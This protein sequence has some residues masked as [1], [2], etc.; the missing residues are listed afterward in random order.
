MAIGALVLLP[1]A[2]IDSGQLVPPF[3]SWS[4]WGWLALL[5]AVPGTG[6]YLMNWAHLHVSLTLTGLLTLAIP[7]L[8]AAGGWL[9]LDQRLAPVQVLGM[10]VVLST[11]VVAVRRDARLHAAGC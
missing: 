10:V 11:L 4:Q 9:V 5:L 6:H 2:A 3:P 7:I 8:S 1:L